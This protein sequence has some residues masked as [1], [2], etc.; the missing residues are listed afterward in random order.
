MG[1]RSTQRNGAHH[2]ADHIWRRWKLLKI[3]IIKVWGWYWV[4]VMSV[5]LNLYE[6]E[7]KYEALK[8]FKMVSKIKM[9]DLVLMLVWACSGMF[10]PPKL[11]SLLRK[12]RIIQADSIGPHTDQ[13]SGPK[14]LKTPHSFI[15]TFVCHHA[16]VRYQTAH[17]QHRLHMQ[18]Y[19]CNIHF[20]CGHTW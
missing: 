10:G 3:L 15:F 19:M 4:N 11:L 7:L 1:P 18:Y 14:N 13:C 6:E 16:H 9:G 8:C 12:T 17:L 2:H 20:Q 5:V